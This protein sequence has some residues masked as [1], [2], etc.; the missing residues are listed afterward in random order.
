M[1]RLALA[2][3][4]LLCAAQACTV[5]VEP[6]EAQC[7]TT[8]DCDARGFSGARCVDQLCEADPWG[9]LG[10]VVEPEPDLTKHVDF[11]VRFSFAIDNLPVS[12]VTVDVCRKID[13]DCSG[14]ATADFP[15]GLTS[16]ANGVVHFS[17]VQGFD[18]YVRVRSPDIVDALVYVGRP[19]LE[20]PGVDEVRLLTPIGYLGLADLAGKEADLTRGTAILLAFNCVGVAASGVR[21]TVPAAVAD[22]GSSEFYLINQAPVTPPDATATDADGFGG[23]YNLIPGQTVATALMAENDFYIGESSFQVLANTIT[24]VLIAPTPK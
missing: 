24:Y 1:T 23:F 21:F 17:V 10:Q 6:G 11:D 8:E 16:D 18:G 2:L 22:A 14:T 9:C 13:F 4:P 7:E 19:L 15:K 5:V 3:V 20:P 12:D